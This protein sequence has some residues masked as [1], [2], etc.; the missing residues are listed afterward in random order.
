MSARIVAVANQKGGPGKT[1]VTM[2]L[3]AGFALR[4]YKVMVVDTD[5]QGS[6]MRWGAAGDGTP[7]PVSVVS[8]S[9]VPDKV[10]R[11]IKKYVQNYDLILIDCPPSITS[12]A[13][14]SALLVSE[15]ALL[16]VRPAPLDLWALQGILTLVETA[17]TVNDE[18]KVMAVINQK[19]PRALLSA[20][21]L[22]VL[23]KLGLTTLDSHLQLLQA[24]QQA[25]LLGTSVYGLG[26]SAK[27][28]IN[29]SE[30]LVI[31]VGKV[32]GED[33]KP[34]KAPWQ[35]WNELVEGSTK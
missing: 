7:F 21:S 17:K 34:I 8:L 33:F 2:V 29:E 6:A 16:P 14:Q 11:E 18:L 30:A 3:A 10:H 24:Y 25:S 32:L 1:T 9:A 35:K 13:T 31:E 5:P 15:L 26:S 19:Q 27:K 23:Q 20:E 22:A 12:P 28:A 4:G